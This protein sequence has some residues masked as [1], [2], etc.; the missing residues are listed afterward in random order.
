MHSHAGYEFP[1][2]IVSASVSCVAGLGIG[3]PVDTSL[4]KL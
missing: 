4:K 2:C 3:T 1:D